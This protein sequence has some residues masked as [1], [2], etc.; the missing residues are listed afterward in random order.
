MTLP[1]VI[2][3]TGPMLSALMAA[4][5]VNRSI[6]AA[7]EQIEHVWSNLPRLLSRIPPEHRTETLVRMCIAV[8]TGLFDSAVNYAWNAAIVELRKKVRR[9]GISVVPQVT[10][11]SSFDESDLLELKDVELLRLCLSLNL[12]SE[13]GFF[14]LDQCRDIRN[15]FSAAH[16]SM[17]ALDEDEFL[18]FLSRV[19]RHALSNERNPRGVDIQAFL[20]ALKKARFNDS[21]FETWRSRIE[22]TFDAQREML[23]GTLHGIYCDPSS[24]EELRLNSLKI[25]EAFVQIISPKAKSD[26]VERHQNYLAKADESRHIASRQF[27]E[28]LGMLSILGDSELHSVIVNACR[29]LMAVHDAYNNFHNEP[30]FAER[31]AGLAAQ[32]RVPESAQHEFVDSVVTCATGNRYGASNAALLSYEK[33][34]RSFSPAEVQIM[35]DLPNKGGTLS[36]RIKSY[37]ACRRRFRGLVE[38]LDSSSVPTKARAKYESWLLE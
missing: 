38:L 11:K 21:Q 7:D 24:G 19:A 18:A 22:N 31:L 20:A 30:P 27:F 33:M 14:L 8:S 2:G 36:G 3:V 25:C 5:G 32:N 6:V 17:G 28:R 10:G 15:N 26:A 13:D 37:P 34:I 4:L 23:F 16:P 29:S 35:L 12:M 1:V 9:F